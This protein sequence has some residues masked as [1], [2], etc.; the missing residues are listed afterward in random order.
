MGGQNYKIAEIFQ[1][2]IA[3]YQGNHGGGPWRRW[4]RTVAEVWRR[5]VAEM[6]RRCGGG[7]RR[8]TGEDQ[9]WTTGWLEQEKWHNQELLE[10]W[11]LKRLW[12]EELNG[13]MENGSIGWKL[14][15]FQGKWSWKSSTECWKKHDGPRSQQ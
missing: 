15:C 13:N 7:Q 4:R 6:W 8:R 14:W 1:R 11:S 9:A 5:I 2:D 3:D 10:H 12:S